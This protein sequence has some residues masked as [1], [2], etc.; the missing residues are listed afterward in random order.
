MLPPSH[1]QTYREFKLNLEE[2]K[3]VLSQDTVDRSHLKSSVA[4][5][6]DFFQNQI[7]TL[8]LEGLEPALEQQVQSV[9]IE[10]DKQLKL[11]NLD[12][13]F[14]QAAK[15]PATAHQRSQQASDRLTLLARYCDF[16]L[17]DQ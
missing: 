14:L 3:D 17:D 7:L 9:H 16:W 2:L 10:M 11:L 1:S 5:L 8:D 15:Q 13:L 12:A 6:Q 4:K